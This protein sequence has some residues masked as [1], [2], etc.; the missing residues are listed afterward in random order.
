MFPNSYKLGNLPNEDIIGDNLGHKRRVTHESMKMVYDKCG[1]QNVLMK[2]GDVLFFNHRTV[3]GSSSNV[4]ESD[5]KS[6]VLQARRDMKSKDENIF[7]K[8]TKYRQNYV[9]KQLKNR[10][11]KLQE[12]NIYGDFK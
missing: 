11:K 3:H 9:V 6:I 7:E 5:R 12:K 1:K 2:P 8:E 10:I 4:S